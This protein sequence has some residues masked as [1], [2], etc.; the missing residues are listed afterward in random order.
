MGIGQRQIDAQRAVVRRILDELDG[1]QHIRPVTVI[2]GLLLGL[3][4]AHVKGIVGAASRCAAPF[5]L[6]VDHP[7]RPWRFGGLV[8]DGAIVGIAEL[9]RHKVVLAAPPDVITRL[10]ESAQEH[11][12][13]R[14]HH[15]EHGAMAAHMG[16]PATHKGA[17][18]GRADRILAK[19]PA[20]GDGVGRD[21]AIQ[22][23][24]HGGRIPHMAQDVAAP[25]IGIKDD[26]VWSSSHVMLCSPKPHDAG[27][28]AC[29]AILPAVHRE[30]QWNGIESNGPPVLNAARS[31]AKPY[32][33]CYIMQ[34]LFI[35][36]A[37]LCNRR[38]IPSMTEHRGR[39]AKRTGGL[40]LSRR[41]LGLSYALCPLLQ[42]AR[43]YPHALYL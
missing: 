12:L 2:V 14:P 34:K 35:A 39:R 18:A 8:L 28:I 38:R 36:I 5:I 27:P 26:D 30:H 42:R 3:Q 43:I 16:I 11:R 6:T 15:M 19:G 7:H 13:I 32:I 22:I 31:F 4:P 33:F 41:G 20:K 37:I 25:L 9:P 29:D 40:Y 17:A 23:G 1:P 10:F 21:Q 24:G